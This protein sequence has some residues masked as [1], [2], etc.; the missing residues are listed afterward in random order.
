MHRDSFW[1]FLSIGSVMVYGV[2]GCDRI[3]SISGCYPD[4]WQRNEVK[5]SS[6]LLE[7]CVLKRNVPHT[8]VRL[9]FPESLRTPATWYTRPLWIVFFRYMHI[10]SFILPHL[11]FG[12]FSLIFGNKTWFLKWSL[13][14]ILWCD[15]RLK[16]FPPLSKRRIHYNSECWVTG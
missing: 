13:D 15:N 2:P 5:M 8:S 1:R 16:I 12:D 14:L 10:L 4:C 3:P 7:W 9:G 6:L 11:F